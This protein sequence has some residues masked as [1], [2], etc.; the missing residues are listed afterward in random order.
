[1]LSTGL[2]DLCKSLKSKL[3]DPNKSIARTTIG[4]VCKLVESI[5]PDSEIYSKVIVPG[6]LSNLADKQNLLRQ[7][8]LAAID[9]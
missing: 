1:M 5:G 7:D 3:E 6:L 9:K 8:A 4:V 2:D